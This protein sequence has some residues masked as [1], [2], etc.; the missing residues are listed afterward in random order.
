MAEHSIETLVALKEL[1]AELALKHGLDF[2]QRSFW[3][4]GEISEK[5]LKHVEGCMSLLENDGSRTI[6]VRINSGGGYCYD[7]LAII[8]RLRAS[9]C[10]IKTEGHGHIMSAATLLLACGHK[11]S[12]S[13]WASFMYHEASYAVG[14]R[15]TEAQAWVAQYANEERVW[16]EAM[17]SFTKMDAD[18]WRELGKHTDKFFTPTELIELGVVDKVF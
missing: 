12:I 5:T 18:Y 7:A 9:K 11:R 6:T 2:N 16:A 8:S 4:T 17:A 15:H 14:G 3:I 1:Q 10:R 13:K